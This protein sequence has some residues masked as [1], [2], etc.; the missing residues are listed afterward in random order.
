MRPQ[1]TTFKSLGSL[2]LFFAIVLAAI[3]GYA[4]NPRRP[5]PADPL[6]V[7]IPVRSVQE[8]TTD[9]E[10]AEATKQLAI[11]HNA[12]AL[13]RLKE[14]AN[15][16]DQRENSIDD[17][18][19]RKDDAKDNNQEMAEASLKIEAKANKEAID[20]LKRLREL[21]EAEV[22][23]AKVQE[24]HADVSIRVLQTERELQNKRIEYGWQSLRGAGDLTENTGYQI[25][26]KLEVNLLE[27]QKK[28]AEATKKVASKQE[29]VVEKRMKLHKAQLKLGI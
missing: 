11:D 19:R 13:N 25:L 17:F 29:E 1:K 16:I 6:M 10:N 2:A 15:A 18:D 7:V 3:A 24:D 20:L 22:E 21:R 9:L 14:I 27:L 5:V 23:V 12:Q 26:N 28:L 4:Q 8:I